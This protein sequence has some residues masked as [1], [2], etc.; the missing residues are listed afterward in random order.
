MRVPRYFLPPGGNL[1]TKGIEL[2]AVV[3]CVTMTVLEEGSDH[4]RAILRWESSR[5]LPYVE[6]EFIL[7]YVQRNETYLLG[8]S[9]RVLEF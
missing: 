5:G 8:E 1:T 9:Q 2:D 3:A 7:Q 6:C 4:P